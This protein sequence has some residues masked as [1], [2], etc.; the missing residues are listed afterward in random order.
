M[1]VPSE[2]GRQS[3]SPPQILTVTLTLFETRG[4]D[5]TH[6][7]AT[8]LQIFRHSYGSV[9]VALLRHVPIYLWISI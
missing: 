3:P 6:H 1:K 4:A 7:I 9:T 8:P 5:Y 2:V